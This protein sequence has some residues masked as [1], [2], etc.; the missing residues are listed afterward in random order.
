MTYVA[1]KKIA[2]VAE[3]E[4]IIR[5][6]G[7][8]LTFA[9]SLS[10]AYGL[11]GLLVHQEVLLPGRKA[12]SPH[13]HTHKEEIFYVLSGYPSLWAGGKYIDLSPGDFVGFPPS[14]D[15][16]HMMVNLGEEPATIL[17]IGTN[18]PEDEIIYVTGPAWQAQNG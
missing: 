7:E 15:Y 3:R 11:D 2:E 18:P 9:R 14:P 5:K 12:S 17:T 6:S 10:D 4:L 8:K 1:V 16:P 13:Y